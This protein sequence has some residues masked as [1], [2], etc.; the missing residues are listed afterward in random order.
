MRT[1]WFILEKEFRQLRRN[2]TLLALLLVAP[3][4]QLLL[5]S[6]A[7]NY[8][9]ENLNLTVVDQDHSPE[10]RRLINKFQYTPYFRLVEARPSVAAAEQ[11]LLENRADLVLVI[12]PHFERNLVRERQGQ[13]QVLVNAINNVKAGL[14]N[15]YAQAI[16]QAYQAEVQPARVQVASPK[17]LEVVPTYWYNPLL[18]YQTFMV[19]G[20]L[21]EIISIVVMFVSTLNIVREKEIGTIEQL[22]VTPIRKWQFILGK[23]I[24]FWLAALYQLT[25]GM[26]LAR[27]LFHTPFVGSVALLYVI[28]AGFLLIPLGIG[29]LISAVSDNQQQAMFVAWFFLMVFI[30]MCGL[31]TPPEYMPT[32]AQAINR[33]NPLYYIIRTSRMILLKGS[34]FANVR[35]EVIAIFVM[36]VA[37]NL[38]AVWRYRKTTG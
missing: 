16:V 17:G 36:A 23:L 20:L 30:L 8:E 7:A 29:L 13:V 38:L 2:R 25:V 6:Y 35:G 26:L 14:A 18:N 10:A 3:L 15:G 27:F 28:T 34:T 19:P 31:F 11:D 4:V 37:I 24:P 1:V 32:W 9:I 22:N 5:L 21:V 33:F 12:P